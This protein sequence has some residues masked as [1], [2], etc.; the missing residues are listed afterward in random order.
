[1]SSNAQVNDLPIH[2]QAPYLANQVLTFTEDALN[3][4]KK[5]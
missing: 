5:Q 2:S 4:C 3:I 1:M